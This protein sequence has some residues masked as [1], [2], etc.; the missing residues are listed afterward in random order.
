VF[1]TEEDRGRADWE[2]LAEG[3]I[4]LYWRDELFEATKGDLR[5]L[6]YRLI[7]VTC[8]TPEQFR[9]AV[10]DALRWEA[11][12][13]YE[14][15]TGNLNALNDALCG[16]PFDG[17]DVAICLRDFH[18][19]AGQEPPFAHGLLDSIERNSRYHLLQGRRLLALVQTNDA[20]FHCEG[21][22]AAS[23]RWNPAEWANAS[24]G[25]S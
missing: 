8:I 5:A 4:N 16:F 14:P 21:L 7:E 6:G 13:G 9:Q 22:G 12:F 20:K 2:L 15:W 1:R 18:V 25:L 10:S 19:I 17:D 24:R 3:A 23:A 11:Q